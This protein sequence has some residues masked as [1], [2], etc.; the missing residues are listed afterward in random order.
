MRK[1]WLAAAILTAVL[2]IIV[3]GVSISEYFHIHTKGLE[4]ASF[5]AI[6]EVVNC[7]IVNASSYATLLG[8]PTAGWGLFFY[9]T[10]GVIALYVRA[11]R[12]PKEVAGGFVL[13]MA[14]AAILW[15]LRM[16]YV[17][18][19]ILHAVCIVCIAQYILNLF[20]LIASLFVSRLSF[21]E[22]FPKIFGKKIIPHVVTTAI[23]FGIGYVFTLSAVKNAAARQMNIDVPSMVND[24]FKQSLYNIKSEDLKDKPT[25]GS[26]DAPITIVEF[27]DFQCPFCRLAAFNIK[28]YL[29]EFRDKV[30][31][32]FLNYPLDN[33]CNQYVQTPMH[34]NACL[35][36]RAAICADQK[37]KFWEYHDGVFK[38]QQKISRE[39]LVK[40]ATDNG[41][42]KAWFEQC[43]DSEESLNRVKED[44]EIGHRIYIAG[45]PSVFINQRQL[46]TWRS[47]EVLRRVLKREIKGL[48]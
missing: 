43:M 44:V 6:N 26:K 48:K 39:L 31:F 42:E 20:L 41:M 24:H 36:A 1:K 11:S 17:S 40:L 16:A 7:D 18:T 34:Q 14:L 5:C 32:A 22:R 33:S 30:K 19:F 46:L 9:I 27:S 35:A 29:Y 3:S 10:V 15:T 45:T 2:G 12:E 28:P 13:A 4:E 25:W 8:I 21:K 23:I 47:P 38:N 37:G